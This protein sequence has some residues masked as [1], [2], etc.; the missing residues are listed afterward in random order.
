MIKITNPAD[1]CGCFACAQVCPR[2]CISM[3][4]DEEGF[5][6]PVIVGGQSRCI[7]C[8]LCEKVCP[9]LH[10]PD[11]VQTIDVWAAKNL[12]ERERLES[13]SGG[14]FVE[15]AKAVIAGGGVVFGAVFDESWE[16]KMAAAETM[17]GVRKMMGSKYVQ[18]RVDTA[19]IGAKRF[20]EQGRQVLFSGTPCQIAG[21]HSFL[22][23]EYDKLLTV[24]ILCYGVPSPAVWMRYLKEASCKLS[25]SDIACIRFKDKRLGWKTPSFTIAHSRNTQDSFSHPHG[26]DPYMRGF[27]SGVYLRPS[28]YSCKSKSGV[29]HSDLTIADFWGINHLMPSFDDDK[30]VSLVLVNSERGKAIFEKLPMEVRHSSLATAKRLN[31]GFCESRKVHPKRAQFYRRFNTGGE[32][33]ERIVTSILRV[34]LHKR[35]VRKAKRLAKQ[36]AKAI[37]PQSAY[38]H[39][40][41]V[42]G[43]K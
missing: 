39:I 5:R 13:S 40:K 37:L 29:S 38:D 4:E 35:A 32:S 2:Q 21:L 23:R 3:Q 27:S 17:D 18:A 28:C 42:I 41:V 36:L 24:D 16:V 20:L 26:Q 43:R 7:N 15:L 19:Y 6:Y 22:S 30:G 1:C 33:I 8:G 34:P 10:R 14:V 9:L 11:P 31:G 25:F 12:D